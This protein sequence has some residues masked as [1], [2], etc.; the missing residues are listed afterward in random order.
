LLKY[1]LLLPHLCHAELTEI[2]CD[3]GSNGRITEIMQDAVVYVIL[4][5][6]VNT[7]I[8]YQTN[9]YDCISIAAGA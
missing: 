7:T 2:A 3:D 1:L 5:V 8:L 4:N 6:S 9:Q